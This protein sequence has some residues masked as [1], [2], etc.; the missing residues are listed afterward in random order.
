MKKYVK[1]LI[2]LAIV[3]V[4]AS[5]VL[6]AKGIK[7]NNWGQLK[8]L[9][10]NTLEIEEI[11]GF[12]TGNRFCDRYLD[13]DVCLYW[14][15]DCTWVSSEPIPLPAEGQCI[16]PPELEGLNCEVFD[17]GPCIFNSLEGCIWKPAGHCTG[18]DG[19]GCEV[20]I[21][22]EQCIFPGNEVCEWVG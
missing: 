4:L 2:V 3:V 14:G 17:E 18:P 7:K 13:R 15:I 20:F 21:I 12:C 6:A 10:I 19:F 1:Y 8:K 11:D 5:S 22:K 16:T 9:S